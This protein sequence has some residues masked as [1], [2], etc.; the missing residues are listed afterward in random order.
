MRRSRALCLPA[1]VICGF[2][3]IPALAVLS[4]S[5]AAAGGSVVTYTPGP[6]SVATITSGTSAAPWNEAQGDP[7]SP[8]YA[9]QAPGTLLPTYTPGGATTGSGAT[10]EPN[11]AVYPGAGSGTD[12]VAPY[13]SGTVGT[14][15]PLAGYCGTGN[16]VTAS[17]GSPA[18]QPAGTTLP[19]APAYFPHVIR[20]ADGTLTGYFD[21]R[22]KDADEALVAATSTDNGQDWTYDGEALEQNPGY[23]PSADINDDGEGHANVLTIGGNTYLYT[24]PRAAGDMQG[25]GMIVHQFSPTQANPLRGLPATEQTG[26]DPDAFVPA[27]TPAISVTSGPAVSIPV[28]SLGTAG[29]P[30]QLVTGSFVDLTQTPGVPTVITCTGLGASSLTGCTTASG[31]SVSV[32]AGDLIEQVLGFTTP[33]SDVGLVVPAGPNTTNGDGGL[34]SF[35]IDST[36]GNSGFADPLTGTTFNNNAPNR[37]YLNGTAIYC[38]QS[39]ANPTTKIENCTTG[40]GNSADTITTGLEPITGDP[41]IPAT[42]DNP[43]A[44]DGMTSGLV[45]PDG[46]VGTLPSYPN[47]AAV[48]SGATYVMYTEKELNYYIAAETL[49]SGTFSSTKGGS[50]TSAPGP[51]ISADLPSSGPWT[52]QIGATQPSA[53]GG[54]TAIIPVTCTGLSETTGTFSG[55]TVPAAD[56]GWTWASNSYIAAPGATTLP[57]ATLALT[58]EGKSADISKLNKNNEDLT[59]LRVAWTT[60]GT[61]FSSAGL[62]NGGIISGE[63]NCASGNPICTSTGSYDDI[64]NPSTTVSPAN[65][66]AYANNDAADGTAPAS[67]G[68]DTGGSPDLDEMRW[69]GS[70]GS[71]IVNP[72][73]SYGLFLSGAWAADGDSDAFNQI[74]YATSANGE[75]WSVPTPVISTDYSFAASA[76]QDTELA[77]G[78]DDPLGISA[79]YSGRAYGPSVV[80]NPNGTL[81]MVFAGYRIPKTIQNAGTVLG[82]N[83]SAPYTIGATDPALY[84][85]IMVTT[86]TSST[87]SPVTTTTSLATSAASPVVGQQVTYTATVA[88]AAPGTGTPTGTVTFTG[89]AGTLCT[90]A[91]SESSPDQATCQATYSAPGSDSVTAAYGGDSNYAASASGPVSETISQDQTTTSLA[92]SP[93][94]PVVGQPVTYTATVA[95]VAPG[96]GTPTGQVTIAGDGGTLCVATLDS[97]VPD[98]A[99]C[100][101]AYGAASPDSVTA[102]YGGDANDQASTSSPA[103]SVPVGEDATSTSITTSDPA[104]VVGETVTYTATVTASS[105]GSGTPTGTVTFTGTSGSSCSAAALNEATPDTATCQITYTAPGTDAVTAAYNSDGNYQASAS[106]A[107]DET[108]S[109]AQTT[110]AVSS[111]PASPVVGQPVTYTAAVAPVSPGA[112]TPTGTVGFTDS[113]GTL[114]GAQ[115]LD[116]GSPDEATCTTTYASAQQDSVTAAYGGDGNFAASTSSPLTVSITP[117]T[118]STSL[119]VDDASPV[120]GQTV[121]FTATV[122]VNAPG[123]SAPTGTVTFAGDSGTLC[124]APLGSSGPYN[125]V[126]TATCAASYPAAGA[127]SVT[128]TY[129]GDLNDV[130]SASGPVAISISPAS[131]STTLSSSDAAPQVGE[132]VTF[133]AT[134]TPAS[135][136]SG[137]ATGTVTFASPAGTLCTE[138]LNQQAPDQAVCTASFA[139]TGASPVTATYNGD[140]NFGGSASGPAGETVSA[141]QT[142]TSLAASVSSSVAGQQVT[143]T[144]DVNVVAPGGGAPAGE[145]AFTQKS[146]SKTTTLCTSGLDDTTPDVATCTTTYATTGNRTVTATYQGTPGYGGS[147]SAPLIISVGSAATTTTLSGPAGPPVTGQGVTFTATVAADAPSAGTPSGK[148]DFTVETA[149]DEQVSCQGG[150]AQSLSSGGVATCTLPGSKLSASGSPLDVLAGYQGTSAYQPS[151]ASTHQAIGQAGTTVAVSSSHNPA[152]PGQAV[153]LTATVQAAPPGGGT[154]AGTVTFSFSAPAPACTGGDTVPLSK[155]GTAVCKI[156]KKMLTSSLT[157][158]ASYPGSGGYESSSGTLDQ[159]VS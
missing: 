156:A 124:S 63:N 86:L 24:L 58:G 47:N 82:T 33:S 25:V 108:I 31:S 55:C 127:D 4:A 20:N 92:A 21:Y 7:A 109:A 96:A 135:P 93:A 159:M 74:F 126:Y 46:I 59:V 144:A 43:A 56:N 120:V 102:A 80:Q 128:A 41:I 39:N 66:N 13:P 48:P 123:A 42:A 65:L 147:A 78:Q 76:T 9:S 158:T 14:P 54:A 98:Q 138:A 136:G 131:T 37:L 29:S 119:R 35:T 79:Y 150:N 137:T 87:A 129:G 101:Y 38:A 71:I 16:Q 122:T 52:V 125:P 105:P 140:P 10:A 68:P 49:S 61:T 153:S 51:Y 77:A 81:T 117:A 143:F 32:Q 91:L 115:P 72:D 88:P 2:T 107:Q 145:V 62:A 152:T 34:A 104:P 149:G 28:T 85:N 121:N 11:V 1:V 97:A 112:G 103:T 44:G 27:G 50:I 111:S 75:Y 99:T 40:P 57:A 69:V 118:T 142:T 60:N 113:A 146:G 5:P 3:F 141:A 6:P 83:T 17:G 132:P 155:A 70:A 114:C 19:F 53:Q 130:T 151:A 30:E 139:A 89:S 90:A 133:T 84:R 22:P 64:S 26:I 110:T 12:G 148:V 15:G 116:T 8:A 73:G 100:S 95:T 67:G 45:A 18:R 154:P 94:S 36:S 134:V 157:V 23:C 106:A